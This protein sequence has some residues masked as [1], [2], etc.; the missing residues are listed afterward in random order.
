MENKNKI[1]VVIN[2]YNAER[3][4]QQVVDTAKCF[5]EIVI[6][7]MESTDKTIDIARQNGCKIVTFEKKNYN[8]CEPARTFAIQSASCEWVLVVDADELIPAALK[9]YLYQEINKPDCPG[10]IYIPRKNYFCNK[11]MHCYYPDPQLR[12]FR[13]EGTVWPPYIHVN[14]SVEGRL[15]YIP[16]KRQDLAFIHLADDGVRV[17]TQKANEYTESEI[18]KR[19]KKNYG[20]AA[21][22]YRPFFRFFK[23]YILKGGFRDGTAGFVRAV[24]QGYYQFIMLAKIWENKQLKNQNKQTNK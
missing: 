18:E 11:F 5:D 6:C 4:L 24:L 13:K 23:A 14:P 12:F 17:I 1:S 16:P 10:G 20:I 2:T 19:A 15:A 22:F 7:D 21:F 9:D 8:I 3:F